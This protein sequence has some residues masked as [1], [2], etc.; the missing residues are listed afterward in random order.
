MLRTERAYVMKQ[1]ARWA[2]IAHLVFA[3]YIYIPLSNYDQRMLHAK[4][5]CI[6]YA[7]KG[8]NPLYLNKSESKFGWNWPRGS[9]EEDFL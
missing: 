7:P 4:Y 6:Y 8:A 2:C 5:L 1:E 9:W 3:I